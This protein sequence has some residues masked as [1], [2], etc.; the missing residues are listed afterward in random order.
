MNENQWGRT[1]TLAAA[2]V[3]AGGAVGAGLVQFRAA[4]R[5][6]SVKGVAERTVKADVALWPLRF[7]AAENDLDAAQHKIEADRRTV[8]RF[9]ERSG[10]DSTHVELQGFEVQDTRTNPYQGGVAPAR[11]IITATLMV[12]SSDPD[13]IQQASQRVGEL[14]SGG[15]VLTGGGWSSGPTFLFTRLNDLKPAMLAEA[16]ANARKAAEEFARESHSAVGGIQRAQQGVFEILPRDPA[17][18]IQQEGQMQKTLRVVT[19]VEYRLR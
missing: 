7:V 2:I 1:L 8:L 10:V 11:Y 18:G 9:L 5:S 4:D 14:V 3:L 19:T 17:P 6:V 13:R 16:T 12:R 15:V